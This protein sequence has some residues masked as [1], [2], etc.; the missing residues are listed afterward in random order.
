MRELDRHYIGGAWVAPVDPTIQEVIDPAT[1]TPVAKVALGT[2]ADVDNAVAAARRA[3]ET[4][5]TTSVDERLRLLERVAAIYERRS[6]DIADAITAEMGAPHWLARSAQAGSGLDNLRATIKALKS[7]AFTS[8]RGSTR[9]RHEPVGVCGLITPWN[10]PIN[11]I[12]SKFSSAV[13]AG[14]TVVLKPSEIAPLD[15][16]IF[17]EIVEEADVPPGV[18]NLVNGEGAVVGEALSA[19]PD[20]DMI[21]FTGSTRAGVRVGKAAAET[22]KRV[23]LELGGKSANVIL[24]SAN[25]EHAVR[26]GTSYCFHNSGQS[27]A[28]PTRMFVPQARHDAAVEIAAATAKQMPIGQPD[29][30]APAIG[31]LVSA[32][33]YERVQGYIRTGIDEGARLAAGG[34]GKP[35]GFD[36]GYYARPTVFANVDNASRIAQ[37]EIFGPVLCVIP[38]ADEDEAVRLANDSAYGLSGYVSGAPEDAERVARRLRTGNVHIN[39]AGIDA[40]APFGGYKRSGNGREHGPLGLAEFLETKAIMTGPKVLG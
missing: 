30:P 18:F 36:T 24:A 19:H 16:L 1:E 11:Q 8:E 25:L 38:Y 15:A 13:A 21:S 9:I 5:S 34:L 3:F 23:C 4:F 6:A 12:T 29:A 10:W 33:Q 39:Y 35:E 27:C 32:A 31:P 17:T 37:E 26:S 7:Y 40:S 2:A 20:V 22:I 28:A 14:C